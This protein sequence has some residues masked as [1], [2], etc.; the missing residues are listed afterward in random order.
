M[1][2]NHFIFFHNL[3]KWL[4][5]AVSLH[6]RISNRL[7]CEIL[8]SFDQRI[9]NCSDTFSFCIRGQ[10]RLADFGYIPEC[11]SK[12]PRGLNEV[13]LPLARMGIGS[14]FVRI[15]FDAA[16]LFS[17]MVIMTSI[18]VTLKSL[19]HFRRQSGFALEWTLYEKV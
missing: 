6:I 12:N 13:S 10:T 7:T 15:H 17:A 2:D 1:D 9:K 3:R 14:M 11:K 16:S 5:S 19:R 18:A 4:K 8:F